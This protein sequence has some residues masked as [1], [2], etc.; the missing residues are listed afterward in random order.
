MTRLFFALL[1]DNLSHSKLG[2]KSR[3]REKAS[4]YPI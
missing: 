2:A 4:S 3:V 1:K